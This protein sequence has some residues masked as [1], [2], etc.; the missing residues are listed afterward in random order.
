MSISLKTHKML[1]GRSGNRCA[2]P[3]CRRTLVEDETETDDA[4][5]VGDEAH[6]VAREPDGPRGDSSLT[7]EER[8]KYDN[9]ILMCKIHHKQID[10]QPEKYTVELLHQIKQEHLD[11]V[12]KNLTPDADKQKD[13]EIYASYVDHWSIL[14][15]I[16][17]WK[18]WTSEIFSAGQPSISVAQFNKLRELNQYI[19]S[20]VWPGRY[21]KIEFAYKNFRLVLNDFI[22]VFNKYKQKIGPDDDPVYWTEKIYKRLNTWDPI[23][24][25]RL[26]KKFDF[27]VDLV[28]DL[29]CE[30]T[31]AANYLCD[32]IRLYI[33]RSYRINEGVLLIESGPDLSMSW[34]TV[35]LEYATKDEKIILY[36]GLKKFME[37]RQERG[38]C[39]GSGVS[40]DYLGLKLE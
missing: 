15:D 12:D 24:Y 5:I 33:S 26:S 22:N 28:Q 25:E 9:L 6:I 37:T 31:R 36:P 29:G 34:T 18:N 16:E 38:Y 8:D 39:F 30:L 2:Y 4:S 40:E 3:T 23:A 35:R 7:P 1:W 27:H 20:R 19:L 13:D 14:A 11:W 17:N 21:E 32:Q 10:D